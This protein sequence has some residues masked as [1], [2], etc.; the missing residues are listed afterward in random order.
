MNRRRAL[1]VGLALAAA[2]CGK[3][4]IAVVPPPAVRPPG[5]GQGAPPP[6]V[7]P[8]APPS[9]AAPTG[10]IERGLASWYGHP[11]HGR[12]AAD[13]EIYDMETLV[14]AHRTL[15]FQTWVRVRHVANGKTV[16]VR[17][18]DRG[19]FV[20]GRI[21]D[22]SHAAAKEIELIGPGVGQVELAMLSAPANPEASWF[23]V[24]VGAFREKMNADR[25]AQNMIASYGA[26]KQVLRSGDPAM[27][28]VLA[29]RENSQ[30]AAEALARRIRREQKVPEAFVVRLDP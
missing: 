4:K 14:A 26:A 30:D 18:I 16:D 11:Y 7:P 19:P 20:R 3:K 15:P 6:S 22:L 8:T 13:G 28:R 23:A 25:M 1:L 24:Q 5:S 27:W 17:I 2:G 9:G 10:L 21:I 12:P 29:G